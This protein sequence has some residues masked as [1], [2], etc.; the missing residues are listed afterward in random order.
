[1]P[2]YCGTCHKIII[3]GHSSTSIMNEEYHPDCLNC[4]RCGVR[5]GNRP[6]IQKRNGEL[7]C[8]GQCED[9]VTL[10]PITSTNPAL[11]RVYSLV[12][13]NKDANALK[14]KINHYQDMMD[15]DSQYDN[16]KNNN[17]NTNNNINLNETHVFY[18]QTQPESNRKSYNL[19]LYKKPPPMLSSS[20]DM[21]RRNDP[22]D[23][24]NSSSDKSKYIY[25]PFSYNHV[26]NGVAQA[27]SPTQRNK[28]KQTEP[29]SYNHREDTN[30]LQNEE[31]TIVKRH[32]TKTIKPVTEP[33]NY[34]RVQEVN[35]PTNEFIVKKNIKPNMNTPYA[36]F[37]PDG[38]INKPISNLSNN[39]SRQI[40]TRYAKPD[41][42]AFLIPKQTLDQYRV[43]NPIDSN[44]ESFQENYQNNFSQKE[45]SDYCDRCHQFIDKDK[46]VFNYKSYH[47]KCY[48]CHR[49]N[50]ELFRMKKV[51]NGM[52]GEGLYCEPCHTDMFGPKCPKCNETV[53]PY[54]LSTMY[55]N[56]LFHK[57]C[58][59]CQRCRRSLANEKFVRSGNLIICKK[60]F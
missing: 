31:A 36:T 32:K 21:F 44:R 47:K 14:E 39:N 2:K 25:E 33:F 42:S 23:P 57:E 60:C 16:I 10:P 11:R 22:N 51:L 37:E 28:F 18:P 34:N 53:T 30:V 15:N 54:M 49:C 12:Q 43:L 48:S 9:A 46:Y 56:K 24:K 13:D 59:V 7:Y 17:F 38:S 5:L 40:E 35:L 55:D 1:M 19:E 3:P 26:N 8:E 20:L 52:D 50:S 41:P 29:F 4:S 27:L 58:F 45:I 6:F